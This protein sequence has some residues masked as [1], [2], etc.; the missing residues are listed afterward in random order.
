MEKAREPG[1]VRYGNFI[2]YYTFNPAS[3]RLKLIDKD[4]IKND[5]KTDENI[6]HVLDIGCNSG[7]SNSL[8]HYIK[9]SEM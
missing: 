1:S 3:E 8:E 2:N 6:F 9:K 5:V 7:V 4:F